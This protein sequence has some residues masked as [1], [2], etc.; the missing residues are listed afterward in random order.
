M[1]A[2]TNMMTAGL[3]ALLTTAPAVIVAA[4][5]IAAAAAVAAAAATTVT[6]PPLVTACTAHCC[7]EVSQCLPP[8]LGCWE[9]RVVCGL[10]CT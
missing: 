2:M 3:K 9:D 10:S 8:A 7:L 6:E 1:T 5:V 4:A